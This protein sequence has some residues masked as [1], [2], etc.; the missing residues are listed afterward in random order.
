MGITIPGSTSLEN[1]E[2]EV[3]KGR[4]PYRRQ[5]T[6]MD[7]SKV[8]IVEKKYHILGL[9]EFTSERKRMS[10]VTQEVSHEGVA[11]KRVV[12][13]LY[14]K[15]TGTKVFDKEKQRA[16]M[17]LNTGSCRWPSLRRHLYRRPSVQSVP[18]LHLHPANTCCNCVAN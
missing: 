7:K 8:Q 17:A 18:Q 5:P 2:K 3:E 4:R 16:L 9:N 1:V 10:I 11:A 14:E 6:G 15:C 13:M 12:H